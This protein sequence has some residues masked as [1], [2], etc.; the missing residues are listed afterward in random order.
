[1]YLDHDIYDKV[2]DC[3]CNKRSN[4]D[5]LCDLRDW[6]CLIVFCNFH[7]SCKICARITLDIGPLQQSKHFVGTLDMFQAYFTSEI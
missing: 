7:I 2:K 6:N 4:I 5:L 1:M 3:T